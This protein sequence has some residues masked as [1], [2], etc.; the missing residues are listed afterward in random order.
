M[1]E[2]INK[3]TLSCKTN[4][5]YKNYF[6]I[7]SH[8]DELLRANK[9]VTIAIEG[10]S[11]SGKSSLA[12]IIKSIYDC[13]VFHMDD[14]FLSNDAKTKERLSEPGGNVDYFRFKKEVSDNLKLDKPFRYQLFSCKLGEL[15]DFVC[16]SPKNLNIIEG[17]Y[18]LH[19]TFDNIYDLKIFLSIDEENQ[20]NRI[21]K[22]N[23]EFMLQRFKNEWIPLENN[24][25]TKL[26]ISSKCDLVIMTQ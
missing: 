9:T 18:S 15:T 22:R 2:S 5:A 26:N 3:T 21:L 10:P 11:G 13:N 20:L 7:F 19:P 1:S 14:F 24:Y 17:V 8:I 6:Q 25:F 4:P 23:G 16:V 12:S